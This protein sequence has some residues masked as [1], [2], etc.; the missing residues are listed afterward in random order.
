[1]RAGTAFFCLLLA[2]FPPLLLAEQENFGRVS[3]TL[4]ALGIPFEERPLPDTYASSI[5]VRTGS[6]AET[7]VLAVPLEADFAVDVGLAL[8]EKAQSQDKPVSIMVA[9]LGGSQK[10]G[11]AEESSGKG[12]RDLLTLADIPE[13]WILCY[14]DVAGSPKEL[15]IRHG[16]LGYAAPLDVLRPLT[17]LL[18]SRGIPWSFR[19]RYNEIYRLGLAESHQAVA[20]AWER[21]INSIALTA[22]YFPFDGLP[23]EADAEIVSP[24]EIAELLLEY[25]ASLDF[26]MLMVENH[27]FFFVAPWGGDVVFFGEGLT[28]ALL[29]IMTG[30]CLLLFLVYSARYNAI[31]LFHVR[32][33]FKSAWIFL[34]LFSLMVVSIRASGLF[35]ATLFRILGPPAGGGQSAQVYFTGA[36]LTMLLA[37]LVFFLHSPVFSKIRIP[38]RAEFYEFSS[39]ILL[40]MGL[41]AAAFI[42]FSFVPAFLWTFFFGFFAAT[43][44]KPLLVFLCIVL[45]PLF[46]LSAL[47]NIIETESIR[48]AEIFISPE[49]RTLD[50]WLPAVMVALFCLPLILIVKRGIILTRKS[51]RLKSRPKSEYRLIVVSV[52][53]FVILAQMVA[54]ILLL[55]GAEG[56]H[57]R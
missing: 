21:E 23:D 31:L 43:L 3:R 24:H 32:L 52:L 48:I 40:V 49:W 55:P 6:A 7:F 28:V 57:H 41:L 10:P 19:I 20:I 44:S 46:A 22:A 50:A 34:L 53:L 5:L 17:S 2:F 27:Y 12:L 26:P 51:L 38:R 37:V 56:L 42:D 30:I 36:A 47:R 16:S 1:M 54:H 35:Y 18:R 45:I 29:L 4:T 39:V 33:F 8:A 11:G 25:A 15:V 14:F 9:F 13:N